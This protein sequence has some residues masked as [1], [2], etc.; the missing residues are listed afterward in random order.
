MNEV[1]QT[2]GGALPASVMAELAAADAEAATLGQPIPEGA[3]GPT[4]PPPPS[5]ADELAAVLLVAGQGAG[6]VFESLRPI[7]TETRCKAVAEQVAPALER[8]GIRLPTGSAGVYL[9][10]AMA[11]LVLGIE[12]REAV[13]RDLARMRREREAAEAKAKDREQAAQPAPAAQEADAPKATE[14][15]VLRPPVLL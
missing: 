10:A 12:T 13:T 1:K 11:V 2:T 9:P 15:D 14:A 5:Q 8:L 3:I 4:P 6:M 7:Y